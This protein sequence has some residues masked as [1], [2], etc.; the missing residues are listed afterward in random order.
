M[1]SQVAIFV[2]DPGLQGPD[3]RRIDAPRRKR[4][5]GTAASSARCIAS[6]ALLHHDPLPRVGGLT[7]GVQIADLCCNGQQSGTSLSG[8]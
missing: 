8:P 5:V 4:C 1:D 7:D 2:D 3:M 6:N